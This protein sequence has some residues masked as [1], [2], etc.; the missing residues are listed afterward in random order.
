MSF[1]SESYYRNKWRRQALEELTEARRIKRDGHAW[2]TVESAVR[3]A[4]SSWRL[5]LSQA[6][7]CELS[8][9]SRNLNRPPKRHKAPYR[10]A[11]FSTRLKESSHV[12]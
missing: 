3:Y 8:R 4:R 12:E 2:Q 10:P 5:Y 9:E 11:S 1:N 6:R 7:I